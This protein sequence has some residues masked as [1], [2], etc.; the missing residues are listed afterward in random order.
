M[1]TDYIQKVK[2]VSRSRQSGFNTEH[3]RLIEVKRRLELGEGLKLIPTSDYEKEQIQKATAEQRVTDPTKTTSKSKFAEFIQSTG[4]TKQVTAKT[5]ATKPQ[6][7]DDLLEALIKNQL[8]QSLKKNGIGNAVMG[9]TF[10]SVYLGQ[11]RS[12]SLRTKMLGKSPLI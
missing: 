1:Q 10:K 5:G 6:K 2:R 11:G 9:T 8:P 4:E 12:N 7:S 3:S